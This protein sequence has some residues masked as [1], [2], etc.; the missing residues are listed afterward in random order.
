MARAYDPGTDSDK[1]LRVERLCFTFEIRPGT[2][3]EYKKRHDEIWPELVEAIKDAGFS[4][5]TL[6]RRGTTVVGYAELEPDVESAFA[7]LG[8]NEANQRWAKW[9]EE[10]I[11][12]LTDEHGQLYRLDEVWHLD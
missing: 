9:F 2:E 4:N 1:E 6:F 8:P 5:Y 7:K 11:V 3:A 12:S 10:V